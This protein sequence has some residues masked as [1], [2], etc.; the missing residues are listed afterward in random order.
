MCLNGSRAF[1]NFAAENWTRAKWA[2]TNGFPGGLKTDLM[3]AVTE[4]R[5]RSAIPDDGRIH[6]ASIERSED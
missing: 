3:A 5:Y 2:L 6:G 1:A 4:Y